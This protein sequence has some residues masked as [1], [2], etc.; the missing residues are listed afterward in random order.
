MKNY[1]Y[2]ISKFKEHEIIF[3][4]RK[5]EKF[6]GGEGFENFFN[7]FFQLNAAIEAYRKGA[8]AIMLGL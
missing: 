2:Y 5:M 7:S 3:V 6:G 8:L 1:L 4:K